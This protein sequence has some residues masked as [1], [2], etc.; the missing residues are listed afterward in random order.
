MQSNWWMNHIKR[1]TSFE[2]PFVMQFCSENATGQFSQDP[3]PLKHEKSVAKHFT[4]SKSRVASH[5]EGLNIDIRTRIFSFSLKFPS[6][7]PQKP[8]F[9]IRIPSHLQTKNSPK[10]QLNMIN[11]FNWIISIKLNWVHSKH[12]KKPKNKN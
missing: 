8:V 3:F 4:K 5:G 12:T 10:A 1:E 9:S 2:H 6:K 11:C 7:T